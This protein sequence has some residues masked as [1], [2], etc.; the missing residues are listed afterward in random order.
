LHYVRRLAFDEKPNYNKIRGFLEKV[1][2]KNG[3]TFDYEYDWIIKK[4][5]QEERKA[6][7]EEQQRALLLS[8]G[9]M[10]PA[11]NKSLNS[12]L[13]KNMALMTSG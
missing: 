2:Q 5:Q 3:W 13:K 11:L 9:I 8:G 6:L 10:N 12:K 7:L 4:R 1:M